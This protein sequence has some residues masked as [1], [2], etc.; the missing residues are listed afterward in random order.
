MADR[1]LMSSD[2]V[3]HVANAVR[4]VDNII[5][6]G[7]KAKVMKYMNIQRIMKKSRDDKRDKHRGFKAKG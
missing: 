4:V 2:A 6:D 3:A 7:D 5:Q 1:F